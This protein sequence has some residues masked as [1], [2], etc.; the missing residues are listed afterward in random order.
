ALAT[1]SL[2]GI[3]CQQYRTCHTGNCPVGI[4]THRDDLRERF[5]VE[6]ST[7]RLVNFFNA[8]R[9]ELKLVCQTNGRKSVHDLQWDDIFTTDYSMH[10]M[11]GI[12]LP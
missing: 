10:K 2:I 9:E 1:A 8:T 11:T 12:D 6:K 5:D 4:T 3:G 7:K